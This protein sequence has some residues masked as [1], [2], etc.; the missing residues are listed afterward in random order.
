MNIVLLKKKLLLFIGNKISQ[1]GIKF[2]F[3]RVKL[4][5]YFHSIDNWRLWKG[6]F[7]ITPYYSQKKIEK[8]LFSLV[9]KWSL[10]VVS[11]RTMFTILGVYWFKKLFQWSWK[12]Y[13][14]KFSRTFE[15]SRKKKLLSIEFWNFV[16]TYL[17][18]R[19][20]KQIFSYLI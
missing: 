15:I 10:C 11:N 17:I 13:N 18:E 3:E 14:L 8:N 2:P 7:Q 1:K 5:I 16:F 4:I 20:I 19:E 6:F 12:L 9:W